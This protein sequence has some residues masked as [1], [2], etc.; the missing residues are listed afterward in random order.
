[1][2]SALTPMLSV[3]SDAPITQTFGCSF[4]I[5]ILAVGCKYR[6]SVDPADE[7][8]GDRSQPPLRPIAETRQRPISPLGLLASDSVVSQCEKLVDHLAME[9]L[10]RM[11]DHL[12]PAVIVRETSIQPFAVKIQMLV[13]EYRRRAQQFDESDC[14]ARCTVNFNEGFI[15]K[16]Q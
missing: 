6:V 4:G 15:H 10:E 5:G 14:A 8:R 12:P 7:T 1:M 2:A 11:P 3:A 9:R 13:K 16:A